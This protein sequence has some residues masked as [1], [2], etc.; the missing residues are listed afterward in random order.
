[1]TEIVCDKFK[2][3]EESSIM[4]AGF[5]PSSR[6]SN[7]HPAARTTQQHPNAISR[8]AIFF[9]LAFNKL[10]SVWPCQRVHFTR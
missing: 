5:S 2:Y 1:M 10:Q 7:N 6:F 9:F 8:N 3:P 4:I